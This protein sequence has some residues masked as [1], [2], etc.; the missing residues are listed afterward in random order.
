VLVRDCS[1]LLGI[2]RARRVV[3]VQD[4]RKVREGDGRNGPE[5]TGDDSQAMDSSQ[6][7]TEDRWRGWTRMRRDALAIEKRVARWSRHVGAALAASMDVDAHVDQARSWEVSFLTPRFATTRASKNKPCLRLPRKVF[8]ATRAVPSANHP[9]GF[10]PR[11][12]AP[13]RTPASSWA[14]SPVGIRV[15]HSRNRAC[16][17][18]W[19]VRRRSSVRQG[20]T[21]HL[22]RQHSH[23]RGAL[24]RCSWPLPRGCTRTCITPSSHPASRSATSNVHRGQLE[25]RSTRTC[26]ACAS[27]TP[28]MTCPTPMR[29]RNFSPRS[30]EES[31]FCPFASVPV[32][33]SVERTQGGGGTSLRH[34]RAD[35][36][37]H[38]IDASRSACHTPV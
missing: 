14:G 26:V 18:T 35:V 28:R 36:E 15:V 34:A 19:R 32:H 23:P 5:R 11:R 3:F 31:N 27:N 9:Q 38:R 33:A 17:S 10:T 25:V 37:A 6:E 24:P 13:R 12:T 21:R 7:G 30:R 8:V 20:G 4:G 16:T 2:A 1:G 22:R 29:K